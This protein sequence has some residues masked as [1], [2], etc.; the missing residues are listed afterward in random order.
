MALDIVV[1]SLQRVELFTGLRPLQVSEI[2]RQAD[3]I[4]YRPG[5]SI[6]TEGEP[7][8]AAVLIVS[9]DA[10]RLSHAHGA[11]AE[12]VPDGSLVGELAMLIETVHTSTVVARGMTR[13]IRITRAGLLDQMEE[14]PAVALVLSSNLARR[15]D[16]VAEEL[17]AI[18]IALE[19]A[20]RDVLAP[21]AAA[22]RPHLAGGEALRLN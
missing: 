9:G 7:G 15:L 19:S 10:V 21:A 22:N 11:P 1:Q 16:G 17:R 4:V 5:Q 13:A 20:A 3:R 18:D 2:A 8:D 14:D 12:A 6:I